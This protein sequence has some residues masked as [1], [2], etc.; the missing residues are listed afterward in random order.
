TPSAA[1]PAGLTEPGLD[2][3]AGPVA[4]PLELR[5]RRCLVAAP[6]LG[7][8]INATGAMDAPMGPPGD[9]VWQ[10]AFWYRGSSVPGAFST[11]VIAGHVDGR[12]L[13]AAFAHLD[14]LRPGDPIIVHNTRTGVDMRFAVTG[15]ESVP[16]EQTTDPAVLSRIYGIGPVVG[17]RPH[18]S[19]DGRSHL[20][21]ITCSGTFR[22]GTHDHRLAVYATRIT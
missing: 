3:H 6:V 18:E 20:T 13:P 17:S 11:A 8:G 1:G 9:P 21:L 10:A 19:V 5:R 4:V 14:A 12:G 15:S 16:L 2:L 7:V 22:N